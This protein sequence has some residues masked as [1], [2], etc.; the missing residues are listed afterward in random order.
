[1]SSLKKKDLFPP[2]VGSIDKRL[3]AQELLGKSKVKKA[4][5]V[6]KKGVVVQ[7]KSGWANSLKKSHS[8]GKLLES[9]A[10]LQPNHRKDT[11]ANFLMTY[12]NDQGRNYNS[13]SL[14]QALNRAA[15][16]LLARKKSQKNAQSILRRIQGEPSRTQNELLV[17]AISSKKEYVNINISIGPKKVKTKKSEGTLKGTKVKE[18][19]SRAPRAFGKN[20]EVLSNQVS[21]EKNT[22]TRKSSAG[23]YGLLGK[24]PSQQPGLAKSRSMKSISIKPSMLEDKHA[25]CPKEKSPVLDRSKKKSKILEKKDK[26]LSPFILPDSNEAKSSRKKS[27]STKMLLADDRETYEQNSTAQK[28]RTSLIHEPPTVKHPSFKKKNNK[29]TI[30]S[31]LISF[32]RKFKR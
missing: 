21:A 22:L 32:H 7:T 10:S 3:L 29:D 13:R 30:S 31:E 23:T 2:Q 6:E 11:S 4:P 16:N 26:M 1:M 17:S 27:K 14:E 20:E 18:N 25:H 28:N 15:N 5:D 19:I 24:E 12:Y 9:K 8:N